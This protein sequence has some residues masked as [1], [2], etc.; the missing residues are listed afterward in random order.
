MSSKGRRAQDWQR[1]AAPGPR[2]T[3]RSPMSRH[4]AVRVA[5]TVCAALAVVPAAA[6]AAPGAG[7]AT[8]FSASFTTQRP[9][10]ASGLVLRTTG[11][12]PQPPTTLAPVIRQTVT[13]P[14]G[15]RLRPGALPQCAISDAALAAQGAQVACPAASRVGSGRAEGVRDG[16]PIGFDLSVYAIRGQLFFAA[17]LDGRPLKRGFWATADGRRLA[18]VVPTFDGQIAPTLFRARIDAGA[19]G[20]PWLRTPGRCPRP[21]RWRV[22]GAFA[23]LWSI[24]DTTPLAPAQVLRGGSA[25]R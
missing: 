16:A 2:A 23:P 8:S 14:K 1:A 21:A 18:L 10:A 20:R 19:V 12:P 5:I 15:T 13:F 9:H 25:C 17:E 7:E 24:Y 4:L 11:R 22:V 3:D 6:Q